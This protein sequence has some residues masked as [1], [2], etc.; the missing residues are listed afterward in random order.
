VAAFDFDGTL[1]SGGSVW[2]FL[3]EIAGFKRVLT[4]AGLLV[5]KLAR[6]ALFGGSAADDAK[7]AL[8][9]RTLAG[10]PIEAVAAR[11]EQFG[12]E[13]YRR[14]AR[15]DVRARMEWHRKN[16]HKLVIVSAS[17][18]LYVRPVGDELEMDAVVA[19]R[20]EVR[21]GLL[22]GRYEGGNCRGAQ[23]LRRLEQW[24]ESTFES[25]P[26][27]WVYGNSAGDLRLLD[28]ADVGIDAGRL[29]RFG[30]L[31]SFRRLTSLGE[32]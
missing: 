17:P 22:T 13:H 1:T 24:I 16:G 21:Q 29:G 10:A 23:K 27:L 14:H 25:R 18:E 31:R 15:D 2:Q 12:P 6:A 4:A 30:R 26:Y 7:E 8:F 20:L 32:V 5:P 11:G 3:V 9:Q 19:T 28:A